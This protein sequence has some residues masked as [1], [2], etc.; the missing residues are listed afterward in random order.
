M[1]SFKGCTT[2]C[3]CAAANRDHLVGVVLWPGRELLCLFAKTVLTR[4]TNWAL[5]G[6]KWGKKGKKRHKNWQKMT[7]LVQLLNR[8]VVYRVSGHPN[9]RVRGQARLDNP[10]RL[11]D[12]PYQPTSPPPFL[13]SMHSGKA[14]IRAPALVLALVRARPLIPRHACAPPW[15]CRAWQ[16]HPHRQGLRA[17]GPRPVPPGSAA[18][19]NRAP[20]GRPSRHRRM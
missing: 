14:F 20:H 6:K 8:F 3:G 7:R 11:T 12:G 19:T 5:I 15:H 9:G 16:Q 13:P 10:D 4:Q 1:S 2:A 17:G 18:C